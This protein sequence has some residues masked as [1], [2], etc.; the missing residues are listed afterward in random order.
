VQSC[1][2]S[3]RELRGHPYVHLTVGAQHAQDSQ[4]VRVRLGD[5]G[6][7]DSASAELLGNESPGTGLL[8]AIP[9]ASTTGGCTDHTRCSVF[10]FGV[11]PSAEAAGGTA[12]VNGDLVEA[13]A[14]KEH[15]HLEQSFPESSALDDGGVLE[16]R[17]WKIVTAGVKEV[18]RQSA[19]DND[20]LFIA[21]C[22]E[23]TKSDHLQASPRLIRLATCHRRR[24]TSR[25][26]RKLPLLIC[27]KQPP[28][29]CDSA[30]RHRYRRRH[31]RIRH[32]A[33]ALACMH[34]RTHTPQLP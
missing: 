10:A 9:E 15:C 18:K 34:A 32:T 17:T 28:M 8:T 21:P 7:E 1:R 24:P 12:H 4:P 16:S 33:G 2:P 26:L 27:Q 31:M 20:A 30:A 6:S 14:S 5:Q 23:P 13:D 25:P 11:T 19:L 29:T 22:A 3:A